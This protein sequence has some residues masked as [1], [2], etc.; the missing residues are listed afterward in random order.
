MTTCH[1]ENKKTAFLTTILKANTWVDV[2]SVGVD[3]M[4]PRL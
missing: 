1:V 2:I 4:F 3:V